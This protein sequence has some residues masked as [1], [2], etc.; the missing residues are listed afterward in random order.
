MADSDIK[1]DSSKSSISQS[2]L[3]SIDAIREAIQSL[4][5]AD[6]YLNR[7]MSW[8][9]FNVRVLEEAANQ[10]HPLLE[11]LRF[12]SIS[13]NNLD[14]FY[15]VRV[16]GLRGQLDVGVDA[17][18]IDGLTPAQ[19]LLNINECA[20]SLMQQ[21]QDIWAKLVVEMDKS[22]IKLLPERIFQKKTKRGLKRIS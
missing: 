19:Q 13:G 17:L 1:T 12:L 21:Q 3:A 20:D 11:R 18:S 4:P 5:V 9:Q 14:E 8:L 7:E 15:M 6:R 16:A 2:N 22:G 10:N